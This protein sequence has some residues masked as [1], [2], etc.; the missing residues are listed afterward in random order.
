MRVFYPIFRWC[1]VTPLIAVSVYQQYYWWANDC[2]NSGNWFAL[3]IWFAVLVSGFVML[4]Y[5]VFPRQ[6][7]KTKHKFR[8]KFYSP[9][10]T[11]IRVC[12]RTYKSIWKYCFKQT[13]RSKSVFFTIE[14]LDT[15]KPSYK[16]HVLA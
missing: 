10:T 12:T 8:C 11:Q 16:N 1:L 7:L 4:G 14:Q 3:L 13:W 2:V 5:T 9:K 6:N 15:E